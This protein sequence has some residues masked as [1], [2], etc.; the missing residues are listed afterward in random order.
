M[1][2]YTCKFRQLY[3]QPQINVDNSGQWFFKNFDMVVPK[4]PFDQQLLW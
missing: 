3:L 1:Q 4:I 2:N